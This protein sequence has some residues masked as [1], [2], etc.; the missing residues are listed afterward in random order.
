MDQLIDSMLYIENKLNISFTIKDFIGSIFELPSGARLKQKFNKHDN[1]YCMYV[2]NNSE[3]YHHCVEVSNFRLYQ[4]MLNLEHPEEGFFGVCW[5]GV[6]EFVLPLQYRDSIVGALI[7]GPFPCAPERAES[8]FKRIAMNY[9]ID[10]DRLRSKYQEHICSR[11]DFDEEALPLLRLISARMSMILDSYNELPG[12]CGAKRQ[13]RILS[14]AINYINRN[15]DQKLTIPIIASICNC[16]EST[17]SH[18]FQ[19]TFGT[20]VAEYIHNLRIA[21]AK[22]ALLYTDKPILH[23]ARSCGFC[24]A[25]HFSNAFRKSTGMTALEYRNSPH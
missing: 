16:S 1:G 15:T 12:Y 21:N 19:K 17:L 14:S 5:C 22:R 11:A 25:A 20:G 24:S 13:H 18:L 6:R 7:A 4:K 3:A 23:I 2:K 8:S 9:E 10:P